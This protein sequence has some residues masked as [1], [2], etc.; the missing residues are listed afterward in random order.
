MSRL[1]SRWLQSL[2]LALLVSVGGWQIYLALGADLS[3][4]S[5]GGFGMFSTT[6]AGGNRHLH[7]FAIYP[8]VR[9]ELPTDSA[10]RDVVLRALTLPDEP[11]LRALAE[12]L[13]DPPDPTWG[14]PSMVEIQVFRTRYDPE[15]LAPR[16]ELLRSMELELGVE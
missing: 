1:R 11:R 16:G 9:V 15:T 7:A 14:R 13:T 4:W 3:A 5:G 2:P 12:V 8:G 6:D 10:P